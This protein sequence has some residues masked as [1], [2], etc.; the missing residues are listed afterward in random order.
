MYGKMARFHLKIQA[1][2]IGIEWYHL[3]ERFPLL[4]EFALTVLAIP[5]SNA[6]QERVVSVVRKNKTEFRSNLYINV[7]LNSI[8]RV[9]MSIPT[10]ESE[11]NVFQKDS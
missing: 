1:K 8:L 4:S 7:S 5:Y 9:K 6:T 11:K 10:R 2:R 3:R